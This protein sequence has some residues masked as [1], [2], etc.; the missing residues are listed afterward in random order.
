MIKGQ[1]DSHP[2]DI[3]IKPNICVEVDGNYW[4]Q[5]GNVERDNFLK[6][7]GYQILH[8]RVTK[9]SRFKLENSAKDFIK[10]II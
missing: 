3:F 4:H 9:Y 7:K 8:W 1:D 2:V 6:S 5:T 10:T